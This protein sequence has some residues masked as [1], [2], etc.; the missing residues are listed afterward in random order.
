MKPIQDSPLLILISA[1][2]GAGKTTLCNNILHARPEIVRAVTCT[3]RAPRPGEEDGKD[4]F[5]L[6]EDEFRE[7]IRGGEFIEYAEVHG[8]YYGVLESE[9]TAKLDDGADVILNIDVQGASSIR[10]ISKSKPRINDALVT[11]FLMPPSFEELERR[12]RRRGT[13]SDEVIRRRLITAAEEIR[14]SDE[15]DYI[16]ISGTFDQDLRRLACVVDAEKMRAH[17]TKIISSEI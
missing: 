17:R 7:K 1:P 11:V 5:F 16:I 12:L 3:T 10:R 6:G 2:S 9:L 13:D 15:F 4:Y 14:H 8:R